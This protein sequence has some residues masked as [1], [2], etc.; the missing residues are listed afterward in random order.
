MEEK[1]Q[2]QWASL[3]VGMRKKLEMSQAELAECIGICRQGI[4]RYECFQRKP[5]IDSRKKISEFVNKK[6]LDFNRLM[7]K[8]KHHIE[9]YKSRQQVETA[10]LEHSSEL[11]ELI[12]VI[13]GDGEI[14]PDG[15]V[16]ISFDPNKEHYYIT[17]R[18]FFLINKILD[19]KI[20]FE[21]YKRLSFYDISFTRYLEEECNLTPGNKF[22]NGWKIP[23]WCFKDKKYLTSIL[24]GLFD[25][26]GYIAYYDGSVTVMMGRF[27]DKCENLVRS[28]TKGFSCL[29]LNY[30]C[31]HTK[32]GRYRIRI[33]NKLNLIRFF[34]LIGSSNLKHIIRFLLW[35]ICSYE[36]KIEKEGLKNLIKRLNSKINIEIR[37]INIP[38]KWNIEQ[39][40]FIEYLKEDIMIK[41]GQ[42]IRNAFKWNEILPKML[43]TETISQVSKDLNINKR[44]VRKWRGGKRN[45]SPRY[46]PYLKAIAKEKGLI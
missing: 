27:S 28:I 2:E 19:V 31:K 21:S 39:S 12:G 3:I 38:F 8:G 32:D 30:V 24:R 33:Q 15:N 1:T 34:E 9:D 25:T 10:N 11:A 23:K 7:K 20:T 37:A 26:D 41:T 17:Q 13:L 18:L 36:A 14:H 16:R 42:K 35:R 43:D 44:S 4:S 5:N 46:M 22:K 6:N 29:Q 45:P 40:N